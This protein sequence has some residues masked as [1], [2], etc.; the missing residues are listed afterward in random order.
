MTRRAQTTVVDDRG[1]TECGIHVIA[2][3][4]SLRVRW[5]ARRG[6]SRGVRADPGPVSRAAPRPAAARLPLALSSLIGRD[7]DVEAIDQALDGHRLVTLTGT[8]GVGKTRLACQVASTRQAVYR[9][10]VRFVE[11]AALAD[12]ALV[13]RALANVLELRAAPRRSLLETLI[14]GSGTG[15]CCWSSTI[16][17]TWSTPAPGWPRHCCR[18]A[19]A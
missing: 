13:P 15:S 5:T 6:V 11:L 12:E 18:R 2:R 19:R 10:G 16:A 9:D 3:A 17:S 4:L 7:R 14:D 1:P 8:G